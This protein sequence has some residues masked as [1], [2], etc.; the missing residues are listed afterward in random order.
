LFDIGLD[1]KYKVKTLQM[2]RGKERR[3]DRAA[4]RRGELGFAIQFAEVS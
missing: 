1:E 2:Q 4:R 3:T